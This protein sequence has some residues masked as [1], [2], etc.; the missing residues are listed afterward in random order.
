MFFQELKQNICNFCSKYVEMI[1]ENSTKYL[2][3]LKTADVLVI[4]ASKWGNART[5]DPVECAMLKFHKKTFQGI[6]VAKSLAQ[7]PY[8]DMYVKQVNTI[9]DKDKRKLYLSFHE[10]VHPKYGIPL[11]VLTDAHAYDLDKNPV[12]YKEMAKKHE[13]WQGKN[14]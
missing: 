6:S 2:D 13:K 4:P 5:F 14:K 9:R 8:D 12:T 7:S 10:P 1:A 11:P 3:V